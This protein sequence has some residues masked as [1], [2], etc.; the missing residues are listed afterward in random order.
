MHKIGLIH[1][2]ARDERPL[3]GLIFCVFMQFSR[4]IDQ[5]IRLTSALKNPGS[6]TDLLKF[7][8]FTWDFKFLLEQQLMRC[9]SSF[10]GMIYVQLM[11]KYFSYGMESRQQ[12]I[13]F[14]VGFT[15]LHVARRLRTWHPSL[16]VR[17]IC[18]FSS[19]LGKIVQNN[20]WHPLSG[21]SLIRHCDG[22]VIII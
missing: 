12:Q 1:G 6:V 13:S 11:K 18:S 15:I 16:P 10:P 7:I 17:P 20:N 3:M 2:G 21:K 4:N 5:N 19:S 8:E 14:D 9:S 22:R